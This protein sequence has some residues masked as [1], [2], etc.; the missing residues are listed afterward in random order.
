MYRWDLVVNSGS[1]GTSESRDPSY[2]L[3]ALGVDGD[4]V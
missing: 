1:A 3:R 4:R 2:A